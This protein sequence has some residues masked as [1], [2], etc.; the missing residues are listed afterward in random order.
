V[1]A[2]YQLGVI[3]R[4]RD[5]LSGPARAV[6]QSMEAIEQTAARAKNVQKWGKQLAKVGAMM[7]IAGGLGAKGITSLVN[8]VRTVEDEAAILQT[9]WTA[10]TG[11]I[12]DSVG[13]A[14]AEARK[15]ARTNS[16]TAAD[17]LR[18][19]FLM[20]SAGL[21]D[22]QA[23]EGTKVALQVATNTKGEAAAAANL[24]ASVYNN[25]GDKAKDAGGELNLLGDKISRTQ[26]FFQFKDLAQL[27]AGL[28]FAT[29]PALQFGVSL[30]QLLVVMGQ[31]NTTAL[32]GS[33]A[34]TGFGATMRQ[35]FKASKD[36][37]FQIAKTS[38]GGVDFIGTLE[39]IQR[40]F[41]N[42]N[43]MTD[44]TKMKLQ[45]AFGAR[46]IAPIALLLPKLDRLKS[47]MG[48]IE[49]A[50]GTN[51]RGMEILGKTATSQFKVL[52]NNVAE[53]KAEF[54]ALFL[55]EIRKL[56]PEVHKL[57]DGIRKW[58]AENPALAE[59][60]V[61]LA[62]WGTI[63]ATVLGPILGLIGSFVAIAAG[64]VIVLANWTVAQATLAA[65]WLVLR[66]LF[67]KAIMLIPRLV[68]AIGVRLVAALRRG[69]LLVRL[70]AVGLFRLVGAAGRAA[71]AL[72]GRLVAGLRVLAGAIMAHPII[73]LGVIIA[74]MVVLAIRR[75]DDLVD[76]YSYGFREL[77]AWT[78]RALNWFGG[79]W[80]GAVDSGRRFLTWLA[81]LPS[82][83]WRLI[84]D[85]VGGWLTKLK[86][87]GSQFYD[88]GKLFGSELLN[89]LK[90]VWRD[91]ETWF[92]SKVNALVDLV[93]DSVVD[94]FEWIAPFRA[95]QI[96]A[97]LLPTPA[98]RRPATATSA[99]IL[100]PSAAGG[101][102]AG[103]LPA[104]TQLSEVSLT[105]TTRERFRELAGFSGDQ[106]RRGDTY[107]IRKVEVKA[108]NADGF[109]DNLKRAARE[110][111]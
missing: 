61:R 46:G 107:N 79:L 27:E 81:E 4:L 29:A 65:G 88:R 21:N 34:G 76:A 51:A 98:N 71:I 14:V 28:T 80:T 60:L 41:G 31:L 18:A 7:V 3:V 93:P 100:N 70:L 75:W 30:D 55:P 8:E 108:N 38:D 97:G 39:N 35:M 26:Q 12:A 74:A 78:N 73:A 67:V 104:P 89:G 20:A 33:N 53:V 69:L 103:S 5:M 62:L 102:G 6:K 2:L 92:Q 96:P 42:F 63:F 85:A 22:V 109:A 25:L 47:A 91:V 86:G 49:G 15:W 83:G 1:E 40:K 17:F 52:K 110:S 37:G 48:E 84:G 24:L 59:Q 32:Q 94:V 58:K 105:P 66:G 82:R 72:G 36:L 57:I 54:G 99:Q 95:V 16:D 19:S 111:A 50:A 44:A 64:V 90:E 101:A 45:Q 23:I 10:T 43:Q 68:M 106:E 77:R 87:M 9:V 56:L 11:T 13:N